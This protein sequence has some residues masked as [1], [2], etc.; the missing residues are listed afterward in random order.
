MV[1]KHLIGWR[2]CRPVLMYGQ[3]GFYTLLGWA[4]RKL[5]LA[6]GKLNPV[7]V[8]PGQRECWGIHWRRL[9]TPKSLGL[10][11][12]TSTSA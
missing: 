1:R 8:R 9:Y 11:L 6:A 12:P 4:D 5:L 10:L 2:P 3:Q 7:P